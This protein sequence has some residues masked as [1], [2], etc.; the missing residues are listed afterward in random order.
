MPLTLVAAVS[1][2]VATSHTVTVPAEPPPN[3]CDPSGLNSKGIDS[4]GEPLIDRVAMPVTASHNLI[5]PS[6]AGTAYHFPS[7]LIPV[8]EMYPACGPNSASYRNVWIS[9]RDAT[10]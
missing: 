10:F 8:G 3:K 7:G 4:P 9:L 6:F 1:S 5:V 2:P